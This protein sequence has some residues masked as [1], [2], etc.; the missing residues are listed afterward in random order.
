MKYKIVNKRK[1]ALVTAAD[2]SLSLAAGLRLISSH[3]KPPPGKNSD[4][5]KRILAIRLA[6]IGDV[7]MTLPVLPA[8]HAA[9]PRARIDFLTAGSAAPL[10]E[11]NPYV[12]R[13]I[14]FDAPWFFP[15]KKSGYTAAMVRKLAAATYDLGFDFRGD[16]RN[17]YHCLWKPGIP[18]RIS[19]SSGGGGVF[20]THPVTWAHLTHKIDYHLD[21]LRKS[22]IAAESV[23]P[24]IYLSKGEQ[25]AAQKL[26]VDVLGGAVPP[27]IAIH[28]GARLALKK[29][30]ARR[31]ADLTRNLVEK[32]DAPIILTGAPTEAADSELIRKKGVIHADLTGKLTIREFAAVIAAC[33]CLICH[34]SAPMH[35]ACAVN[36]PV[37]ALFGP[38]RPE[39][40]APY[41]QNDIVLEAP[42]PVKDTCDENRCITGQGCIQ[43]I[44]VKSVSEAC[45]QI[46]GV[47]GTR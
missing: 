29:W 33:R 28:P 22:G 1:K 4:R 46:H 11:N 30:P 10:L 31:F 35:I 17:I 14:S 8:L 25:A 16:I 21:L 19:Y 3:R 6:Y 39:E 38:S 44:D 15:G 47:S 42:C 36:T 45:L 13:V 32:T 37:V 23:L 40:T 43:T 34:D 18:H 9:F 24:R 41:G 27:P 26:L 12:H 7:I 20:L 2:F 5:I